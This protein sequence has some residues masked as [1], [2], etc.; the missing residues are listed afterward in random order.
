[1]STERTEDAAARPISILR[2]SVEGCLVIQP[3]RFDDHRGYFEPTFDPAGFKAHGLP[4]HFFQDNL[5]HSK[6]GVIRG[7]HS[8]RQVPQGKLVRCVSGKIWDVCVDLR[9]KSPTFGQHSWVILDAKESPWFWIPPGCGHAF[10]ALED[11]T[12]YYKCTMPYSPMFD[13]GVNW[14]DPKLGIMWPNTAR[15][16][17]EKDSLLPSLADYLETLS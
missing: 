7:I 2:A 16:I 17:S 13:G 3:P 15:I 14:K 9:P 6:E 12:V 1:M 10:V 5:S 11:S 4:E 8:Q